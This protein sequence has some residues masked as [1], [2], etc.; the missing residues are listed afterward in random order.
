MP[1]FEVPVFWEMQAIMVIEAKDK[2]AA[3]DKAYKTW[4]L[5]S[6]FTEGPTYDPDSFKVVYH[7]VIEIKK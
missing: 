1:T 7:S 6:E 3:I 5:A 2:Q 4:E